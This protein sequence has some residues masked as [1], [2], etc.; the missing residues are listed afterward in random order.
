MSHALAMGWLG[1]CL[2]YSVAEEHNVHRKIPMIEE[3]L[4]SSSILR[5]LKGVEQCL[6]DCESVADVDFNS[7]TCTKVSKG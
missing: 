6:R 1:M 3:R 2:S 7:I 5:R 4:Y